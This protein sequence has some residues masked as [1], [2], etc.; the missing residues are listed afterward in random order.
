MKHPGLRS[1]KVITEIDMSFFFYTCL[2]PGFQLVSAVSLRIF[3][4]TQ[5]RG[6]NENIPWFETTSDQPENLRVW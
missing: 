4:Q 2:L 3:R 1:E 5:K 6:W